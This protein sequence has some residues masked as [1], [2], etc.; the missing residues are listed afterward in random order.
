MAAAVALLTFGAGATAAG[1]SFRSDRPQD[2]PTDAPLGIVGNPCCGVEVARLDPVTLMP[3]RRRADLGEYHDTYSFSPNGRAIA[4]GI[5][6]PGGGAGGRI[7]IRLVDAREL[8]VIG[9]I[10]TGVFAAALAWLEPRR[11]I[12]L[13]EFSVFPC[14]DPPCAPPTPF[15]PDET[16]VVAVD[17]ATGEV[18]ARHQVPFPCDTAEVRGQALLSLAGRGLSIVRSDGGVETVRLPRPFR[19]CGE[20][21]TPVGEREAAVVAQGGGVVAEIALES[22]HLSVHELPGRRAGDVDAVALGGHRLLLVQR[23]RRAQPNGVVLIDAET[24]SRKTIDPSA[25]EARV[26]GRTLLTFDGRP[27]AAGSGIGVRGYRLDG[28]RRFQVLRGEHV[29]DVEVAGRFAYALGNSGVAAIDTRS[30][31]VVRRSPSQ[32]HGHVLSELS[33]PCS[34]C[35][36]RGA[37]ARFDSRFGGS[38]SARQTRT[39]PLRYCGLV[40]QENAES[41]KQLSE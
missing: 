36:P 28:R 3:T 6:A 12:A 5:S 34:P 33:N 1:E 29:A 38:C 17:P 19:R 7:G 23:G 18:L 41:F 27:V 16:T 20:I 10:A 9:D 24:Q 39:S 32:F 15:D 11:L 22:S 13:L 35:A 26:N 4:F 40:S 14:D 2:L 8:A 31:S 30:G 37:G 21:A 25:G